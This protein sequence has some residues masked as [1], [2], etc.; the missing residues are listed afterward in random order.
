MYVG[1]DVSGCVQHNVAASQENFN[2]PKRLSPRVT[3]LPPAAA[4]VVLLAPANGAVRGL[5]AAG[6]AQQQQITN[7]WIMLAED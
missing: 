2:S 7:A 4:G 3:V 1:V 5:V 6:P